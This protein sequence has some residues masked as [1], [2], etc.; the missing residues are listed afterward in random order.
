M[1]SVYGKIRNE[2]LPVLKAIVLIFKKHNLQVGLHGT[3]LW[4][5]KYTDI[6]VLVTSAKNGVKDFYAAIEN[7]KK[8]HQ[9]TISK[10]KGN[11]TVG[12]DYEMKI[13]NAI[14]HCSYVVPL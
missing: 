1:D 9:I 2:D 10:M 8:E 14:I 5:P 7:L 13:A 6:D 3:S 11:E 4:N 12:L